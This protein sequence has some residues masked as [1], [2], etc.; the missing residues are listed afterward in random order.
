MANTDNYETTR[1]KNCSEMCF[2]LFSIIIIFG[3]QYRETLS[4]PNLSGYS[5]V[6]LFL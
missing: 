5:A 1:R 4:I 3:D 2:Y 6:I